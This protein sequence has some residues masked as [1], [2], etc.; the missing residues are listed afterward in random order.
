MIVLRSLTYK[1]FQRQLAESACDRLLV[2][3]LGAYVEECF[4]AFTLTEVEKTLQRCAATLPQL[5]PAVLWS[6]LRW[7]PEPTAGEL[8]ALQRGL[9][10]TPDREYCHRAL[11]VAVGYALTTEGRPSDAIRLLD[12]TRGA[13]DRLGTGMPLE[14]LQAALERNLGI[15]FQHVGHFEQA[16]VALQKSLVLCKK[17]DLALMLTVTT[18]LG[19]LLW[20]SGQ[21]VQA[22]A[23]HTDA[24]LRTRARAA[25][26]TMLLARSHLSAA[27]CAIDLK[28]TD[29]AREE[30]AAARDVLASS[31]ADLPAEHAYALLFEGE[32]RVQAGDFDG[33][34]ER[35]QQAQRAFETCRPPHY[36]GALEAKIAQVHFCLYENDFRSAFVFIRKLLD[37][38]EERGCMQARSRLL[39]LETYLVFTAD[40]EMRAA[41]DDV[42]SRVHLINNP[43]LLLRAL[44]NLLTYAVEFLDERQQ[45]FLFERIQ[46]LRPVLEQSCFE[47]LYQRYVTERYAYA[48]EKRLARTTSGDRIRDL[49]AGDEPPDA[50]SDDRR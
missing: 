44:G 17:H 15:A 5:L 50:G 8:L 19:T 35:I 7:R 41:F 11:D 32:I 3:A 39:L 43:A 23:L 29:L 26:A 33:G 31:R 2:T 9:P 13:V 37:E 28:R 45:A 24:E 48:I 20:A 42:V 18:Q 49:E 21:C 36:P 38:A 46:N 30:L 1:E 6:M 25:Q 4:G 16:R 27:K 47:D 34:L 12:S 22:L 40:T 10:D 14:C